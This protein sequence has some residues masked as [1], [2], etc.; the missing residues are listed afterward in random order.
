MFPLTN[1]T[2]PVGG[3][4]GEETVL[5]Q[6]RTFQKSS[7]V[8]LRASFSSSHT[9]LCVGVAHLAFL[10]SAE[11]RAL[12]VLGIS[13]ETMRRSEEAKFA[14]EELASP[15]LDDLV[16]NLYHKIKMKLR[17]STEKKDRQKGGGVQCERTENLQVGTRYATVR[18]VR[19]T[20]TSQRFELFLFGNLV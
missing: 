19:Q 12:Q 17:C 8:L 4:I 15:N 6:E 14:I 5:F 1:E 13:T 7:E 18:L 11:D 2:Q 20:L 9:T 16:L 3:A 10:C